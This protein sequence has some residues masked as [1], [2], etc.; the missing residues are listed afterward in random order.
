MEREKVKPHL[1]LSAPW[2]KC[3]VGVTEDCELR[4]SQTLNSLTVKRSYSSLAIIIEIE[5]SIDYTKRL[6]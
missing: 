6:D 2:L 4:V 3:R 5:Y 1:L